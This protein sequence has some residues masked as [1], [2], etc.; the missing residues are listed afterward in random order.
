MKK[1]I[2][3][4]LAV[5][6]LTALLA[7]CGN[8]A[9][10]GSASAPTE[11]A[12]SETASLSESTA[13]SDA[14]EPA[15]EGGGD[16][17]TYKIAFMYGHFTDKVGSQFKSSMEYVAAEMNIDFAFIEAGYGEEALAAIEA[18]VAA[19][20]IDGIIAA[21]AASP[22]LIEACGG[23]PIISVCNGPASEQEAQE[24]ATY[25]NFLGSVMDSDYEAGYAAAQALYDAG[26]RNVCLAGLTQG[27]TRSNDD[28]ANAFK[29]FLAEHED[30][31]LL[32]D[33]YS[34]GL[35]ADSVSSF[36]AA[37]PE[38]DGIFVTSG[39][40]AVLN[41]MMTEGLV[42]S[43]K[44]ATVD[45]STE[46]GAYFENDTLVYSTGGQY[47]SAQIGLAIL[48]NY[49]AD[50]TRI[51]GDTSGTLTR[52]YITMNSLEEFNTYT[53]YVESGVPVYTA[54]ELLD[55]IH[56]YNADVNEE[57]FVKI[58]DDYSLEDV[59]ERHKD[60]I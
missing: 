19:G 54:A 11:N 40:D 18:A 48:Y 38:M 7:A 33:D 6:L 58:C 29:D 25:D 26:C 15:T 24:V 27:M 12:S 34:R 3:M 16:L 53:E 41:T 55:M 23:V 1:L 44:L 2:G 52:D 46:T 51:I 36:A 32:A 17:P 31:V 5:C 30:M 43:V 22:A 50:G 10:S 28:R 8:S 13:E 14:G 60:L 42:G 45:V 9:G 57:F 47:G 35:F 56:Y 4:V 20:D 21:Q 39:S 49:L 37:Y 59:Y